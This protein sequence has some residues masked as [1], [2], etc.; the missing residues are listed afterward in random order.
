MR[1]VVANSHVAGVHGGAE[2]LAANL[3]REL[4]RTRGISAKLLRI[5]FDWSS[6]EDL[7]TQVLGL[8]N[9]DLGAID[10]LIPLKFPAYFLQAPRRT[11]W[12]VHQFRQA[13]D[14]HGGPFTFF[15]NSQKGQDVRRALIEQDTLE[16]PRY[17]RLFT[18]SSVTQNR[19]FS[20]NGIG[21]DIL[22]APV[23]TPDLFA[24]EDFE[25]FLF[26]GGRIN[27]SKRQKLVLDALAATAPDVRVVI[28]GPCEDD[29]YLADMRRLI[30][31]RELGDRVILKP[32]FLPREEIIDYNNRCLAAVY[33]PVDEDSFGYVAM[34]ASQSGKA[35]VTT[36]DSGGVADLVEDGL[37]GF[38]TAPTAEALGDAMQSL[39]T[40]RHATRDMG[41]RARERL[42]SFGLTWDRT[43]EMLLS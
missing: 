34:E 41:K 19:L 33:V 25:D 10:L 20:Y 18:N 9:L 8:R 35:L 17:D 36:L 30:Q 38:V 4:G 1:I 2:E 15:E 16:L 6:Q 32:T 27:A 12:I 11:A 28:A 22:H 21:S 5:P 13:Y 40:D 29:T 14:M 3:V 37:S 39:W 24:C 42:D 43:I 31:E 7:L 23:N 26:V